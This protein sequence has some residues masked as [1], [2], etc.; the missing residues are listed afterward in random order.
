MLLNRIAST[1]SLALLTWSLS[2]TATFAQQEAPAEPVMIKI[3][4]CEKHPKKKE[5]VVL[6]QPMLQTM[7]GGQVNVRIGKGFD[8]L[9]VNAEHLIGLIFEAKIPRRVDKKYELQLKIV[10]GDQRQVED[11]PD[12]EIFTEEK[13]SVHTWA[14]ASKIK[15][16]RISPTKWCELTLTDPRTTAAAESEAATMTADPHW[17]GYAEAAPHA[18]AYPSTTQ[19]R[20]VPPLI[21][22]PPYRLQSK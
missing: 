17:R 4:I 21:A 15:K 8:P 14:E 9:P 20:I 18:T 3:R 2:G 7:L 16:I 1:V 12:T 5:P 13:L 11:D 19:G 22:R 10:Q 6:T